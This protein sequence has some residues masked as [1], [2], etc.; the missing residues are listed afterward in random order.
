MVMGYMYINKSALN[1]SVVQESVPATALLAEGEMK[2][3]GPTK[4]RTLESDALP[5]ALR[6]TAAFLGK[7]ITIS[8]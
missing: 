1:M 7:V 6:G 2:V 4:Y 8:R 3:C 5:T